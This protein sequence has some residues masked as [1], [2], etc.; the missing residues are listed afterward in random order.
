MYKFVT[1]TVLISSV[2]ADIFLFYQN[3]FKAQNPVRVF[4]EW[5]PLI[6]FWTLCIDYSYL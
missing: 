2:V 6:V 4:S 3:V 1:S 5:I